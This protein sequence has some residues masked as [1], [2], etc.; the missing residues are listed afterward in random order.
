[1]KGWLFDD[2]FR[3]DK[4]AGPKG[5]PAFIFKHNHVVGQTVKPIGDRADSA[6]HLLRAIQAGIESDDHPFTFM[7]I[8]G[9]SVYQPFKMRQNRS[10]FPVIPSQASWHE[11]PLVINRERDNKRSG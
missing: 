4:R 10:E 2:V 5:K 7:V 11:T 6:Q 8:R 3:E 1:L 9:L